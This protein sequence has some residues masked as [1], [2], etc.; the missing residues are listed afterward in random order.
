M[1][2][3]MREWPSFPEPTTTQIDR[4]RLNAAIEDA[5]KNG[6]SVRRNDH[7]PRLTYMEAQ[8]W[9]KHHGMEIISPFYGGHI[10]VVACREADAVWGTKTV[11]REVDRQVVVPLLTFRL[12]VLLGFYRIQY[13]FNPLTNGEL[14][15]GP[16][17]F[18]PAIPRTCEA[19]S[20]IV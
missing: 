4:R 6:R 14:S 11:Y 9:A 13:C 16:P 17:L 2:F 1:C 20:R 10:F 5:K 15:V 8:E 19:V 18:C 3:K 12:M 7:E